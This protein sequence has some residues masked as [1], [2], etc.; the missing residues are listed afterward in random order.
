[1]DLTKGVAVCQVD[2]DHISLVADHGQV[3]YREV[4]ECA[5]VVLVAVDVSHLQVDVLNSAEEGLVDT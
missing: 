5:L 1:M 3:E 2:W 4:S